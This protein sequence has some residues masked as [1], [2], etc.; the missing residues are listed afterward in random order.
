MEVKIG[1]VFK[2]YRNECKGWEYIE[3]Q[4]NVFKSTWS[5]QIPTK[6]HETQVEDWLRIH[7]QITKAL[8]HRVQGKG[9]F[10]DQPHRLQKV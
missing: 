6:V 10:W 1:Q 2:K 5:L 8:A 9:Y 7:T 3:I 4:S